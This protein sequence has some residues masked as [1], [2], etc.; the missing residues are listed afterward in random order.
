M[1]LND[2]EKGQVAGLDVVRDS[3]DDGHAGKYRATRLELPGNFAVCYRLPRSRVHL[4]NA[5]LKKG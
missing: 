3:R 2:Q 5:G 1:P 4:G